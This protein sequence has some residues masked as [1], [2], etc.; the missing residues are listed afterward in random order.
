MLRDLVEA[1]RRTSIFS[2]QLQLLQEITAY[3][4][5]TGPRGGRFYYTPE[6]QKVYRKI[7]GKTLK[8]RK[9]P[10]A[11]TIE[12][13]TKAWTEQGE[14]FGLSKGEISSVMA[15]LRRT[16][17][18]KLPIPETFKEMFSAPGMN[19]KNIELDTLYH[20]GSPYGV[21]LSFNLVDDAGKVMG[22]VTRN[23]T[24]HIQQTKPRV[25]HDFFSLLEDY[26]G[27]GRAA[28]L[29]EKSLKGYQ[30]LGVG[31]V[32]VYASLDAGPYTWAK[33]G[34]KP[35]SYTLGNMQQ[36][37]AAMLEDRY[38]IPAAQVTKLLKRV[39]SIKD[40]ANLKYTAKLPNKDGKLVATTIPVGKNFLLYGNEGHS[41][42][43]E[44]DFNVQDPKAVKVWKAQCRKGEKVRAVALRDGSGNAPIPR[45]KLTARRD[46][47][48]KLSNLHKQSGPIDLA[49]LGEG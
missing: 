20:D 44:G 11:T 31:E 14:V 23:F 15:T 29:L 40:L 18:D 37:L 32:S 13:F 17:P 4:M 41:R 1:V 42:S 33:F 8:R 38:G 26:Q 36:E 3:V 5:Q 12:D 46:I 34:F 45:Q 2:H 7:G 28:V 35:G 27:G 30:E 39:K 10:K 6:G 47:R 25:K 43:W 24:R 9:L 49:Q 48:D 19:M 16:F 22:E 21:S